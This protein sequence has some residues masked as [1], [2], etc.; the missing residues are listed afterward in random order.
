M[1]T[2]TLSEIAERCGAALDGDGQQPISGPATLR[3]GG[4]GE[5][6]LFTHP[7]YRAEFEATR[8][9]AVVVRADFPAE[10]AAPAGVALLRCKDPNRAF[11]EIIRCFA[12]AEDVPAAGVDERAAIH[13]SAELAP[14]VSIGPFCSIGPG[15]VLGP[16][17]RLE[18]GVSI[19][20]GARVGADSRLHPNVTLYRGVTLGE[21]CIV[22]AGAV[23]GADGFG[24]EPT[25]EGWV[26]VPQAGTVAVEDDVEIG[27]CVTIDRARFGAT[28]IGRGSKLDNLVHLAHNV[29]VGAGSLI[30]AQA[31]VAGSTRLGARS[32][33]AGQVGVSGHLEIGAGA[34][35]AAK[36]GV[37]RDLE[38]NQDY[39]GNPA[40]PRAE[41]LREWANQRRLPELM[42]RVKKLERQLAEHEARINSGSTSSGEQ[43]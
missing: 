26:K 40:R 18:A 23:L 17:V 10:A 1:T 20:A 43:L 32:I 4:P 6:S 41:R 31:G 24:F 27:A 2:R 38:P 11:T 3:D 33:L 34:R 7:K 5:V 39:L 9:S 13:P 14:D 22:H 8:A 35:V 36:S 25:A 16:R 15:A 12:P 28:R 42:E 29:E 19:G 30:I 21:R 37:T